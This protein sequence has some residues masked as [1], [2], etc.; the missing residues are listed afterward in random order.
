[1]TDLSYM[2]AR[3]SFRVVSTIIPLFN[4]QPLG[5]GERDDERDKQEEE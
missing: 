1:M 3:W 4:F 2:Y 5:T